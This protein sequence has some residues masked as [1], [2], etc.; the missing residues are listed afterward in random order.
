MALRTAKKG[1]NPGEQ[2]WGCTK[3]PRCRG[4]RNVRDESEPAEPSRKSRL[5]PD[6]LLPVEWI[7]GVRRADFI[8]E[9]V[10]V[11]AVPGILQ[12]RLGDDAR[13]TRAL[14][15]CVLLSRRSRERGEGVEH[16]RFA[17]TLLIKLL[18]R[19]HT[20]LAT[21][22]VEREGLRTHG[23]LGSGKRNRRRWDG[24]W[25]GATARPHRCV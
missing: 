1:R 7:E 5:S 20:P 4:T 9:Y 10:S 8:P 21:L 23:L 16:V 24:C 2:F 25:L 13:L 22:D 18:R 17:T 11:G 14:S 19:G 6:A 15:Q 12:D 3:F